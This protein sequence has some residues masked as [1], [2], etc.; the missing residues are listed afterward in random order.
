MGDAHVLSL[1]KYS[2]LSKA[3]NTAINPPIIYL[4]SICMDLMQY[5]IPICVRS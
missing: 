3:K 2:P 5:L 4:G 1:G